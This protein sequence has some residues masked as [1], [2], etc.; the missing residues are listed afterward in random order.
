MAITH[1]RQ[2]FDQVLAERIDASVRSVARHWLALV[3]CLL[4]QLT[5]LPWLAP[6]FMHVGWVQPARLIYTVYSLLCHQLPERSWFLFGS[7]F[8]PTLA[9]INRASG[10]DSNFH[11]LRQFIGNPEMGW[12]LAWSDRMVSFYGGMFLF[13][14]I[15]A[16]IRQVRPQWRG[17][18][19]RMALLLLV[20]LLLDGLTHMVSDFW[21][22]G[23]G[24]RDSNAW[25]LA[26]TGGL[27]SPTFYAGDAWGS[28]NSLARL[29]TGLLAAG[30][31]VL[32]LFPVLDRAFRQ[33][34]N[35]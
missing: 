27:L 31:L 33:I 1:P 13:G 28:F 7:A 2:G 8:T 5:G 11:I 18:S 26:L 25:L 9:Q 17:I 20:P 34:E 21:G 3:N 24:F 29:V 19:W 15:Y 10:A 6:V 22:V 32:W 4:G 14:L 23:A 30:G 35:S 12:K 16:L